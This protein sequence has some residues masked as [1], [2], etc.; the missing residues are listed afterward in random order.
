MLGRRSATELSLALQYV[1]YESGEEGRRVSGFCV[2]YKELNK[3][4]KSGSKDRTLHRVEQAVASIWTRGSSF[5]SSVLFMSLGG[6]RAEP[7]G[8]VCNSLP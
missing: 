6:W 1:C 5:F 3:R 7:Q 4:E 2:S 8:K